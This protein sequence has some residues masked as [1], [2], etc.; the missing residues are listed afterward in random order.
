MA[1]AVNIKDE[2]GPSNEVRRQLQLKKTEV[3]LLIISCQDNSKR[4]FMHRL[5]LA[6]QCM[7]LAINVMHGRGPSNAMRTQLQ[8]KKIEVRLY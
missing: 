1:L 3:A 2:R 8:P 5:L 6:R 4:H 7:A